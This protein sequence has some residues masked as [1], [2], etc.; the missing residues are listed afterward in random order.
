M[1]AD[2]PAVPVPVLCLAGPTASGK[3]ALALELAKELDCEIINA[4]SRQTYAD[5]PIITAQPDKEEKG[6]VPH[7]LYGCMPTS[8]KLNAWEWAR[9]ACDKAREILGRGY[10]PLLVG[11]SGFYFEALLSGLPAIPPVAEKYVKYYS[12]R[13]EDHGAPALY[14][15]LAQID[16]VYAAKI[17]PNDRQRIERAL[18]VFMGTGKNFTWWLENGKTKALCA[19]PLFVLD[20][21]LRDLESVISRRIEKMEALGAREEVIRA[22]KNCPD[23]SAP[24]WSGI[25]C[26]EY[27]DY[28]LGRIDWKE[29]QRRWKANTRAYAKRQITWFR[30]RKNAIPVSGQPEALFAQPLLREFRKEMDLYRINA[31]STLT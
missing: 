18:A 14:T 31:A 11:G 5:F 27:L 8:G 23:M 10:T 2:A 7:H 28:L 19:G 16:P 17:H 15:E 24:G 4:D 12:R 29:R 9:R 26:R 30:G 25:G 13:M 6:Q 22:W 1:K 21:S 20:A 3:T